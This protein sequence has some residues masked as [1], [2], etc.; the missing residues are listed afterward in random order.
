MS[1]CDCCGEEE[2][3]EENGEEKKYESYIRAGELA[4]QV[5]GE[6][7]QVAQERLK[8]L[9]PYAIEEVKKLNEEERRSVGLK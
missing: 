1:D 3:E 8:E 6:T 2:E 7:S 4:V 9:W 5:E